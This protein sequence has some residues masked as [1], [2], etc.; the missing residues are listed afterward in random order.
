MQTNRDLKQH[1][2]KLKSKPYVERLADFHLLLWLAE[3]SG[4][5]MTSDI[6]II[7]EAVM[8][9]SEVMEGYQ[10]MIDSVAGL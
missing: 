4:L 9:K 6:P 2:Q 7:A 1:L 10:M 5:G 8:H 3:N